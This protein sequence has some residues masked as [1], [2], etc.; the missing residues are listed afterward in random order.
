[1]KGLHSP[2]FREGEL[3]I[4]LMAGFSSFVLV[5]Q[6]FQPA[7]GHSLERLCYYCL[8]FPIRVYLWFQTILEDWP[9]TQSSLPWQ[10]AEKLF[11][12]PAT[13]TLS[14]SKCEDSLY[15]KAMLRQAQHDNSRNPRVWDFFSN[16]LEEPIFPHLWLS[17]ISTNPSPSLSPCGCSP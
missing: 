5:A 17:L 15:I 8:V 6:V 2:P 9:L 7:L 11:L 12:R 13:V 4:S 16:L 1:M 14:L 3:C 10:G